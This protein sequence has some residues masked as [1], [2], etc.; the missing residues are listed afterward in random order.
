M[1]SFFDK[2]ADKGN[3]IPRKFLKKIFK[4]QFKF[5][6]IFTNFLSKISNSFSM[7]PGNW[8]QIDIIY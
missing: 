2:S 8:I 3:A 5:L 7:S 6:Q 4:I 1:L